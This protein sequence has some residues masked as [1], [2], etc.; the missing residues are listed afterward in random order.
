MPTL[1][2]IILSL[3]LTAAVNTSYAAACTYQNMP[4]NPYTVTTQIQANNGYFDTYMH[5]ANHQQCT[6]SPL[7]NVKVITEA[8][9]R[10][11][12]NVRYYPTTIETGMT[13]AAT[14]FLTVDVTNIQSNPISWHIDVSHIA[15]GT[16]I[17]E[18]KSYYCRLEVKD[19]FLGKYL[20]TVC[21]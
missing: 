11:H 8:S 12:P 21:N 6:S 7:S 13:I 2:R 5:N 9:N 1:N 4:S 16:A 17:K 15:N 14:D 18:R 20:Q 19:G 3:V 10:S